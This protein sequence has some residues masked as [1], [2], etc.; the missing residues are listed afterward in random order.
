[1]HG[2]DSEDISETKVGRKYRPSQREKS[3]IKG[4]KKNAHINH[5][6]LVSGGLSGRK[7]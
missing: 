5:V 2:S 4:Q 6:I 3:E 1:M 7:I